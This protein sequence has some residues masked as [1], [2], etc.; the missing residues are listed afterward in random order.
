MLVGI[1]EQLRCGSSLAQ[2]MQE[3]SSWFEASEV[4][5]VQAGQHSGTLPEVLR[6]LAE[7]HERTGELSQKL[8]NALAYPCIVAVVGLG[9]VAFLSVKTL[10][11]L[12]RTLVDAGVETPALTVAVMSFGQLLAH[13][14][15]A[16]GLGLLAIGFIALGAPGTAVSLGIEWPRW[17][18]RFS[19]KV[20]RRIAVARLSLQLADLLRSGV[21][22]V[23]SL[24]VLA[25]T[26]SGSRN[27]LHRQLLAA[28][29]KV[30]RGEE[31]SAAFDD[32]HWFDAQYRRLLEIGQTSGELDALLERVGHRYTRQA[33]RLIDRLAALLE[34]CVILTLAALVGL[35]VMAA[36]LPLLR[37]QEVL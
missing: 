35:V 3:H 15:L 6:S 24:R 29:D 26:A 36:V 23:E 22:M 30:E 11:Q 21:P 19:P 8:M 32:E 27:G 14:W 16:I 9:V 25:P 2:A 13:H 37:L 20:V 12:T 31:V 28:A 18:R 34:P 4:A 5:M 33:T 1:R 7:R 10:P 17:F